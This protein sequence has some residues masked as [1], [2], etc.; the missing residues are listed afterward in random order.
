[1]LAVDG[2]GNVTVGAGNLVIGTSG[3][4]IDFSATAGTGTSELLADYEEGTWTPALKF[5]GASVGMTGTFTGRYTK[6]GRLVYA[7]AD[8][9]LT[10]KGSSTGNNSITGL[11]YTSADAST[12]IV[13]PTANMAG[14][15]AGGAIPM[16]I[17]ATTCY[18][19]VQVAGGRNLLTDANFTNTSVF[20]FSLCYE[21]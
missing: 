6:V 21:V 14:L 17:S 3:K 18:M 16:G 19:F 5:G 2:V 12:G 20:R 9:T 11:P 1:M 13:D 8:I 15:T 7:Y 10:A 4:G